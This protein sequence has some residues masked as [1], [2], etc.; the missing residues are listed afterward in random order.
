MPLFYERASCFMLVLAL[1]LFLGGCGENG[2]V[3]DQSVDRDQNGFP[4]SVK[5]PVGK[6]S[7]KNGDFF[8]I[9][10]A[11]AYTLRP[12]E[13]KDYAPGVAAWGDKLKP[14]MKAIA[15]SRDLIPLGLGHNVKVSI[16][17]LSGKYRVLDKMN[18]RW[19]HRIDILFGNDVALAKQWGKRK[20][21]ISW[22]VPKE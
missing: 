5:G 13:T 11:S 10:K 1:C 8:L 9:V 7:K 4:I 21:V 17:G 18:K 14:G 12:E 15:V 6:I 19:N 3:V 20:V 22:A 16:R 2:V